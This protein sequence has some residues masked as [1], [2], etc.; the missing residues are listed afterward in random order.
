MY[1]FLHIKLPDFQHKVKTQRKRLIKCGEKYFIILFTHFRYGGF[2]WSSL[3]INILLFIQLFKEIC[4]KHNHELLSIIQLLYFDCK[5]KN[6]ELST[7][8]KSVVF[9]FSTLKAKK[10]KIM[11]KIYLEC[12][13]GTFHHLLSFASTYLHFEKKITFIVTLYI[14]IIPNFKFI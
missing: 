9:F 2:F 3:I 12:D 7:E 10:V 8:T 11:L 5:K 13:L 6:C 4:I 14:L 1:F